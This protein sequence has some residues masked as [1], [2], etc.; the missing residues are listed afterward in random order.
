[1]LH[2]SLILSSHSIR[3]SEMEVKTHFFASE[4]NCNHGKAD[5]NQITCKRKCMNGI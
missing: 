3:V 1:M 5:E 2:P 4:K